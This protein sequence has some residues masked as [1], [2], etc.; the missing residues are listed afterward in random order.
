MHVAGQ[1]VIQ[2]ASQPG[3]TVGQL[4]GER[5]LPRL[6]PPRGLCEGAVQTTPPF[7]LETYLQCGL[8][9]RQSNIPFVGDD[10][11]AIS[12]EGMRPAR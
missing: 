10:G 1:E 12:L 9:T 8:A 2:A 7:G 5:S 3:D 11:T 6:Q 4:V